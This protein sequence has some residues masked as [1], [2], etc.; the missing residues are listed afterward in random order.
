MK[1]RFKRVSIS[2]FVRKNEEKIKKSG[3]TYTLPGRPLQKS[4]KGMF[5]F[6]LIVLPAFTVAG[7]IFFLPFSLHDI[8]GLIKR[9]VS[10][11][12]PVEQV[13]HIEQEGT[14][15]P[16]KQRNRPILRGTIYDRNMEE[17]SVSYRLFTLLVQP[18]EVANREMVAEQ[19]ALILAMEKKE[20]VQRLQYGEG[21]V[22]LAD[23]LEIQQVE[24]LERLQLPG[25]HCRPTEVRY[26]PDHAVAGQLLGFVSGHA[27]LSGVEA[28]YDAVLEPGEF[29]HTNI[30][31]LDFSGY[32]ALGETVSD[33]VLTIDMELQRQL[34]LALEEYLQRKGANGGSAIAIDPDT[35]R[36]LAMVGQPGFDSNYFWQADEQKAHNALFAPRYH[37][38]LLRP[39]LVQAA[40]LLENGMTSV[41]PV[42]MSLPEYGLPEN[43]L[44]DYWQQLG[45]GLPVP[46][47]LPISSERKEVTPPSV[48]TVGAIGSSGPLSSLQIIYGIAT[49]LN[50]G[51]RVKPWLLH[52]VYD[53]A[54][55]RFFYRDDTVS[56]RERI[57]PP[58]Q[59]IRL[60]RELL[61]DPSFSEEGSFVFAHSV[62][63]HF[64]QN[65]LSTH[66]IQEL[67]LTAAPLERPEILLLFTVDYGTLDPHP[68][69]VEDRSI[70]E[71][72][73][74]GRKIQPNLVGYGGIVTD[75][76]KPLPEQN[77]V[78]LRRYF[79]SKKL[80]SAEVKEKSVHTEPTMP[81]LVG[82]TLRKGLQQ[83]NRYSIKVRIHG[84]GR[85]VKQKP[86]AG[87][88]LNEI[89]L[90]ELTLETEQ[91]N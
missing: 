28:L 54:E 91:N 25:I 21:I 17:M 26:Y 41:L 32:S 15:T 59:G 74:M 72:S 87:E 60:R 7:V 80:R 35:G 64:V 51:Y 9:P 69:E 90:C 58:V 61:N 57:L 45:L 33:V 36:I 89:E 52:G 70:G 29:R 8:A 83:I 38:D 78:N 14:N 66:Y 68:A 11:S 49:L 40:A 12:Q 5:F 23:D 31:D 77:V 50:S 4:R 30:P 48:G 79:L 81:A 6:L 1:E 65:G 67:F 2:F 88:L 27:G 42:G 46:D 44:Y 43:V 85:I 84:T 10:I 73:E 62:V 18:V 63:T 16:L 86:A 47:F 13:G 24:E 56:S 82:M 53:H 19:L 39:L 55:E 37:Q 71:L 75:V 20:I 34:D 76:T 3:Y 22:E